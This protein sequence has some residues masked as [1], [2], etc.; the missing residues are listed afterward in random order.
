[1]TDKDVSTRRP[2]AKGEPDR[3]HERPTLPKP[4]ALIPATDPS[5]VLGL[6][7]RKLI[8]VLLAFS[9]NA[10]V[11]NDGPYS[12]AAIR[13]REGMGQVT[14]H[15][16]AELRQSLSRLR[17]TPVQITLAGQTAML[18]LLADYDLP[19]GGTQLTWTF[20]PHVLQ[21]MRMPT[22]WSKL[23]LDVCARLRR[24]A[25]LILYEVLAAYPDRK[26]QKAIYEPDQ[27][28]EVLSLPPGSYRDWTDLWSR[29]VGPA[30]RDINAF[31]D[32][33]VRAYP[34]KNRGSRRVVSVTLHCT[35]LG[36][37]NGRD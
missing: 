19:R 30:V 35:R 36:N 9:W 8:N 28:K 20:P 29:A 13:L 34:A 26:Y 10:V 18:P 4:G 21:A 25:S 2:G 37:K 23:N 17:S 11:K 5:G 6:C 12:I 1:M 32:F 24:K 15:K 3:L 22:P 14:Q 27:L 31:A 16:N 33:Q 7:D